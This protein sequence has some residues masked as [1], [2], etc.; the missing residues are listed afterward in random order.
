VAVI[1]P[2]VHVGKAVVHGIGSV[3]NP[4]AAAV[5]TEKAATKPAAKPAAA[6]A[7]PAAAAKTGSRKLLDFGWGAMAGPTAEQD[8]AQQAIQNAVSG[9]ESVANAAQGAVLGE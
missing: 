1:K 8:A 2:N 7:A 3:L 9:D 5:T 4:T 6:A